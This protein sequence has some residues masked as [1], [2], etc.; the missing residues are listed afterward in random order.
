MLPAEPANGRTAAVLLALT[1]FLAPA[2][3]VPGAA[4]LQDTL[5][6][7]I[8]AF[9]TL[10][11][12]LL[13][14]LAQRRRQAPLRWHAIAWLPLLLLAHALASMAWSHPYLA[15]VEAV[16]WFV[17]ALMV[18]LG[19]HTLGRD[20]LPLLAA[21]VHGG[22]LVASVWAALQF[23]GGLEVFP[24]GPQPAST[25]VNRN[26]FAEFAVCTLP[27]SMLLLARARRAGAVVLLAASNGLV[28]T[29]LLMTGTRSALV[30][31]ALQVLVVF[32]VIVWRC[33]GQLAAAT[34][35]RRW[36][37]LAPALLVG[38][39]L[40]LGAIPT[41]SAKILA[42]GQGATALA[43]GLHRTHA[44]APGDRSVAVRMVMWRATLAAIRA[45]PL[46][47]LGAG[48]WEAKIPLYQ[49]DGEQLETDYYA[50][51]E[52]LQLVAEYGVAGWIF[53]LLL[54]AW[55][56]QAAW[57]TWCQGGV[58]ADRPWRAV[59]LCSLLALMVVSAIGFP[60]RL[61]STGALF[62][63]CLG[64]LAASDARLQAGPPRLA[65]PL[66]WS[67]RRA[68]GGIAA[69]VA[70]LLL[71]VFLTDRAG[72]SESKLM[73]AVQLA[74]AIS[75]EGDPDDPRKSEMLELVAQGIALN[76][77]YRKLTP[78]V[79]DEL[80]R[81]G[82]WR[83]ATWIWDSVLRSR[84]YIVAILTNAARGHASMGDE[85]TAFAYLERARQLQPNAPAVR[86][87]EVLLLARTGDA[88]RARQ[89]AGEALAAGI[90]DVDLVNAAFVLAWRAHDYPQAASLL[91]QRMAQW[92]DTRA[93]GLIQ[94]GKMAA[95]QHQPEQ[96]LAWFRQGLQAAGPRE[97]ES[98]LQQVPEGLRPRL[99]A[100][101]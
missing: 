58:E 39:V 81:W 38:T 40:V 59:F 10:A 33:R 64:A 78:V 11:A 60:W 43:R 100:A 15:G 42:E 24:Q 93:R 20:R 19:L 36:Q 26:F 37:W 54:A 96:A 67:P 44:I 86:S 87:L 63:L 72:R 91:Q 23:W 16:R 56:L 101:P 61:A 84:P 83:A 68:Q 48:A 70:C 52:F 98:L 13:F 75:A 57:R 29:A 34:W 99:A 92:P 90:R 8:V 85:Q 1:I 66:P 41:G 51:N 31:L 88:S 47:G 79:A 12:A 95:E 97:R 80:A 4:M 65:R 5:K 30:A 94:M 62:A 76:P 82:D 27:F 3:G 89:R 71:A 18:W 25:F 28:V 46:A 2:L 49:A 17:F 73:G 45:E 53:L 9:G 74:V 7:A 77:H 6:S 35:P 32:P 21:C 50:H 69:A 22:A 55:L 14:L